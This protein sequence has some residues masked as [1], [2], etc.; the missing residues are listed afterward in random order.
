MEPLPLSLVSKPRAT[1]HYFTS[2]QNL[3]LNVGTACFLGKRLVYFLGKDC[4]RFPSLEKI[5]LITRN[6]FVPYEFAS[7]MKSAYSFGSIL[8]DGWEVISSEED[9]HKDV[10]M[11]REG[12]MPIED[13][14]IGVKTWMVY[15]SA[16]ALFKGVSS[17]L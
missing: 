3:L 2:M 13:S 16:S 14:Y 10:R 15:M 12:D 8:K 17:I 4:K 9:V 11:K 1:Y 6:Y 7:A 5:D